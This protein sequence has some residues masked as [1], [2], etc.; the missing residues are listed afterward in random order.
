MTLFLPQL[1]KTL[2]AY[3]A[4]VPAISEER[5]GRLAALVNY[6]LEQKR[7]GAP[8]LLNFICTHN[9]RRSHLGQIWAKVAAEHCGVAEVA[10]FSGGTE[11]TAFN[12]RAVAALV[13]AGF[14]VEKSPGNNPLY[15][16]R[17]ATD[18][19]PLSCFSKTYDD[20]TNP[21]SGFAAVMTCTDADQNCPAILG[22][23]R[24]SLPYRDPKE[25]DDTAAETGRYDERSQQIA[26]E[27][28]YVFSE[29]AKHL[30]PQ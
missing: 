1:S 15:S 4:E 12:P 24:I 29:V 22:A 27:M 11:A 7:V 8:V 5:R 3:L 18:V 26:T 20:A 21:T 10:T 6:I 23:V 2:S 13:R 19:A 25:A 28:L 30:T 14:Q 9:S 17:F 16:V